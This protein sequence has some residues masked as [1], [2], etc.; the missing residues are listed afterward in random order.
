MIIKRK[1]PEI[2]REF[3]WFRK[4][5]LQKAISMRNHL[6]NSRR[7]AEEAGNIK[8]QDEELMK[9]ATKLMEDNN[10]AYYNYNPFN[11]GSSGALRTVTGVRNGMYL[12]LLKDTNINKENVSKF[13]DDG[14]FAESM[15]QVF[16]PKGKGVEEAFHE[17]GHLMHKN[18]IFEFIANN[19]S[20]REK[21]LRIPTGTSKRFPL[22]SY[23]GRRITSSSILKEEARASRIGLKNMKASKATK[24]QIDAAR[25]KYDLALK[26]YRERM[27]AYRNEPIL[28][29]LKRFGG[30]KIRKKP[31]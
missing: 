11:E 25:N 4:K 7:L 18:D 22:A 30:K 1:Y 10:I 13:I 23:I 20:L 28:E 5:A 26:S 29:F 24:E 3:S 27:K 14:R 8:I 2:Q 17:A 15:G 21:I 9:K 12:D 16:V 31:N 6:K 19:P